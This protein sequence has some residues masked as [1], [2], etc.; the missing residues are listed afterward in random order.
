MSYLLNPEENIYYKVINF[1]L[2]LYKFVVI[3][4]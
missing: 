2:S 4:M 1:Y 3:V